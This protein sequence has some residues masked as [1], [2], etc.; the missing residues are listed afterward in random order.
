MTV[1]SLI[2]KLEKISNE[3]YGEAEVFI[4]SE[5]RA[6]NYHFVKI[7]SACLELEENVGKDMLILYE[8]REGE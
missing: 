6:F 7:G 5:A 2:R 1:N 3:G 8:A 4:D